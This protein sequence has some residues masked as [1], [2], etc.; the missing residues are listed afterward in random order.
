MTNPLIQR[1][2]L[3]LEK[4]DGALNL[5]IGVLYARPGQI[6]DD[7]LFSNEVGSSNYESF[8]NLLGEKI[9]LKDWKK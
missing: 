2:L 9:T 3:S 6:F 8:L 7:E 1:D 5:K 4:Q